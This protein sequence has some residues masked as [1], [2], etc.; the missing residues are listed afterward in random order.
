MTWFSINTV[1]NYDDHCYGDS[2]W[3]QSCNWYFLWQGRTK[4]KKLKL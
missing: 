2:N 3:D 4:V 1:W